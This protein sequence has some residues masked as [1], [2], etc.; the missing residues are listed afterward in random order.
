MDEISQQMSAEAEIVHVVSYGQIILLITTI[1]CN[2]ESERSTS[3]PHILN[4]QHYPL[5]FQRGLW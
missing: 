2:A 3:V 4:R 5:K 1:I